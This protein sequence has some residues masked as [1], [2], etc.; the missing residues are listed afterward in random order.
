MLFVK[1]WL[2]IAACS[3]T[4]AQVVDPCGRGSVTDR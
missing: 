3:A 2:E 4:T 1:I